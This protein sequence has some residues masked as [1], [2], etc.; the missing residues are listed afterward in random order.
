MIHHT[1]ATAKVDHILSTA[2]SWWYDTGA[3]ERL[4]CFTSLASFNY[5]SMW[6]QHMDR[7]GKGL[8]EERREE[9]NCTS[10]AVELESSFQ[11]IPKRIFFNR[12]G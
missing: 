1:P 5:A 12:Q 3:M 6:S 7:H 2:K 8:G 4:F 11:P 10:L 9:G